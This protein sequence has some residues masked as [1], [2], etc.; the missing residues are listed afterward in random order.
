MKIGGERKKDGKEKESKKE[1]KET[2]EQERKSSKNFKKILISIRVDTNLTVDALF[3]AS[4][5]EKPKYSNPMPI[6]LLR[7]DPK[8]RFTTPNPILTMTS[9]IMDTVLFR[10]LT[11]SA[12]YLNFFQ[13]N[14]F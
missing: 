1:R 9:K 4:I 13:E 8:R 12:N 6:T 10:Q 2:Y 14:S 3:K 7:D 11:S 5:L